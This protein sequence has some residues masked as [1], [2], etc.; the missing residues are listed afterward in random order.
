MPEARDGSS[1]CV[2]KA[3]LGAIEQPETGASLYTSV[4]AGIVALSG[5]AVVGRK[6]IAS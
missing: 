4:L 5:V 3:V 2:E 1:F 6:F